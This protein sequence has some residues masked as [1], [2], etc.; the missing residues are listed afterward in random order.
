MDRTILKDECDLSSKIQGRILDYDIIVIGHMRCNRYFNENPE[1]SLRGFPLTCTSVLVKGK[2]YVLLI[3]P[4]HRNCA[5]D[6]YFDLN[7]RTG[8]FP[9]DITHCY[10]THEHI[11]HQ[12]GLN[13]FPKATWLAAKPVVEKLSNSEYITPNRILEAEGEFLPGV[14]SVPLPGHTIAQ[15]GVAF[16]HEGRIV[17]A[18]GDATKTKYHFR[19]NS[20][21]PSDEDTEAAV[22]SVYYIKKVTDIVIPGHDNL[23]INT[24][25]I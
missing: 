21:D 19:D 20:P 23:I 13:Y 6:F 18:A 22:R 14:Y 17:I 3:D 10:C 2:G 7:R 11:D 4:T 1:K 5:E 12:Y 15:H 24:R 16:I 25:V 8:L 9:E